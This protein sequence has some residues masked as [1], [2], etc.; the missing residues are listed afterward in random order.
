MVKVDAI[1]QTMV[2]YGCERWVVQDWV[3]ALKNFSPTLQLVFFARISGLRGVE[4]A[5]ALKLSDT[6]IGRHAEELRDS[7]LSF[8]DASRM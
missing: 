2:E 6:S 4:I 5:K 7:L 8:F 3:Q 1:Y